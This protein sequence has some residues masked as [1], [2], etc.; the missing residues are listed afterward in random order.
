[1]Q[2]KARALL[3]DLYDLFNRKTQDKKKAWNYLLEFLLID[4][5]VTHIF[6]IDH[7]FEWLFSDLGLV[8]KTREIYDDKLLR[9]D[10]HDHL[11]DMYLDHFVPKSRVLKARNYIRNESTLDVLADTLLPVLD[12][13]FRFLDIEA[14]T[15]RLIMAAY[16]KAPEAYF[17]GVERN[18][19]LYRIALTN[20]A[21]HD[22]PAVILNADLGKYETDISLPNGRYNWQFANVWNIDTKQLRLNSNNYST[23][24]S[25]IKQK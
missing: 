25:L 1:M 23:K 14:G 7:K 13:P 21:I 3:E 18:L 22:I 6:E 5:N 12:G 8:K 10:G 4:S 16:K 20:L 15:G 11:G 9:E 19:D 24:P 17:F 2:P